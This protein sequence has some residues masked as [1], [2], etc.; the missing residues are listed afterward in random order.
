MTTETVASPV[1]STARQTVGRLAMQAALRAQSTPMLVT[2]LD[3]LV[4]IGHT[5]ITPVERRQLQELHGQGEDQSECEGK[6]KG[7]SGDAPAAT[8]RMRGGHAGDDGE[9]IYTLMMTSGSTGR[10]KAV[11]ISEARF[12]AEILSQ[13]QSGPVVQLSFT[14]CSLYG[15]RL[16]VWGFAVCGGRTGFAPAAEG[17]DEALAAVR[18]TIFSAPP[19]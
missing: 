9:P 16:G 3:E 5:P 18:P 19:M 12:R 2:S 17:L 7:E 15:D 10:S 4:E 6:G 8:G 11:V 1:V 14:P 13:P